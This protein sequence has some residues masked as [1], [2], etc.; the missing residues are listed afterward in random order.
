MVIAVNKWD[1]RLNRERNTEGLGDGGQLGTT[2]RHALI[3]AFTKDIRHEL[4]FASYAPIVFISALKRKAIT[5]LLTTVAEVAEQHAMRVP[6]SE[7]NR[8]LAEAVFDRP[9]SRRGKQLKIYYGT[10]ARVKPP[11]FILF[12]NDTELM[13][14]S[15]ERYIENQLRKRFTLEG[16]PIRMIIRESTGK[17]ADEPKKVRKKRG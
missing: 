13:H 6:T 4:I 17:E 9:M 7:L 8:V 10:Q 1:E 15:A 5:D 11:T 2:E 16:T 14:F 12:V 3:E